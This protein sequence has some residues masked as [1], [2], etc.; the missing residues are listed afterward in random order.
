MFKAVLLYFLVLAGGSVHSTTLI[1]AA[2]LDDQEPMASTLR[3]VEAEY[4]THVK[5]IE[6]EIFKI[7]SNYSKVPKTEKNKKEAVEQLKVFFARNSYF[8]RNIGYGTALNYSEYYIDNHADVTP[9][10]IKEQLIRLIAQERQSYYDQRS[11]DPAFKRFDL[12]N[13]IEVIVKEG[14]FVKTYTVRPMNYNSVLERMPALQNKWP[15]RFVPGYAEKAEVIVVPI[16]DAP[17][18]YLL[19][20]NGS[21]EMNTL[22]LRISTFVEIHPELYVG[23]Q[24]YHQRA[25]GHDLQGKDILKYIEAVKSNP[26]AFVASD[27]MDTSQQLRL[28]QEREFLFETILPLLHK[29][30]NSVF[31]GVFSDGKL[32]VISHEFLHAQ[33]FTNPEIKSSV[34]NFWQNKVHQDDKLAFKEAVKIHYNTADEELMANEFFA[35]ILEKDAEINFKYNSVMLALV[36]KYKEAYLDYFAA[37]NI[38]V[39]R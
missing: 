15:R 3:H 39:V 17:G 6:H 36:T 2:A 12:S 27:S 19:I 29:N 38:K 4:K 24:L 18:V 23:N 11:K 32:R 9:S 34:I 5:G 1:C 35:F 22:L 7:L 20:V 16:K 33:F 14:E 28:N 25:A 37:K 31:L 21:V 13:P 8:E 26:L 30:S 10:L